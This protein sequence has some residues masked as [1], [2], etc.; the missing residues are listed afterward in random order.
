MERESI[1]IYIEK[2]I[3]LIR[4]AIKR[5]M[6]KH[7]L[8][9]G[10]PD[11]I[12]FEDKDLE[13]VALKELYLAWDKYDKSKGMQST[14]FFKVIYNKIHAYIAHH[15]IKCKGDI[16]QE[17][18]PE[19]SYGKSDIVWTQLDFTETYYLD[20]IIHDNNEKEYIIDELMK[21]LTKNQKKVIIDHYF[22][23][24]SFV[25]IAKKMNTTTKYVYQ[26]HANALQKMNNTRIKSLLL[27]N[28]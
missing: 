17:L 27:E 25:D 3:K 1:E 12:F 11:K 15:Y 21:H 7:P 10:H 14:F 9:R 18:N 24:I 8:H 23:N 20:T 6:L 2:N 5:A 13:Q 22:Q 28:L 4:L 16:T 19:N 26:L